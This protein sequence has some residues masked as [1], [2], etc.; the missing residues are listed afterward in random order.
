MA[1]DI[2]KMARTRRTVVGGIF[3]ELYR[4]PY[5]VT[6]QYKFARYTH[7]HVCGA[8]LIAPD[9]VLSA[10]HCYESSWGTPQVVIGDY[11]LSDN[12]YST[13]VFDVELLAI[14]PDWSFDY[15]GNPWFL[16]D[17]ILFKI[18]NGEQ[19]TKQPIRLNSNPNIPSPSHNKDK[20]VVMGWGA[21]EYSAKSTRLKE[22]TLE[23]QPDYM[24]FSSFPDQNIDPSILLCAQDL[25]GVVN[26]D[27][28][29]GDSGGPIIIKGGSS[30]QDLQ[31]G[32]VS[33]GPMPCA[34]DKPGYYTEISYFYDWIKQLTCNS[35]ASPPSHF[36]CPPTPSIT[37]GLRQ[38]PSMQPSSLME[39]T[40]SK[41]PITIA[42][43]ADKYPGDISWSIH[44]SKVQGGGLIYRSDPG[45]YDSREY[46]LDFIYETIYL[47]K[48]DSYVFTI[49]D[50]RGDGICCSE[51]FGYYFLYYGTKEEKGNF[52]E[53]K[54]IFWNIGDFQSST[55]RFFTTG[56][57]TLQAQSVTS[58]SFSE[59]DPY[60][61]IQLMLD[62]F[63]FH[64]SWDI[65]SAD[66]NNRMTVFAQKSKASY[67]VSS[68][69]LIT[70]IVH[71]PASKPFTFIIK[72]EHN[73]CLG[74]IGYVKVFEGSVYDQK[75][76]FERRNTF[77]SD[78]F[79][80]ILKGKT[81]SPSMAPSQQPSGVPS[82]Q[83]LSPQVVN[84]TSVPRISSS[85]MHNNPY[86]PLTSAPIFSIFIILIFLLF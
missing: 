27:S 46:Y 65:T 9:I 3:S 59:D 33:S 40:E 26:E 84:I 2:D 44:K 39:P 55:Q 60:I 25:D 17:L 85:D 49:S 73:N 76:L 70:E 1:S 81:L 48:N 54:R 68:K 74:D 19:S 61:T 50:A 22:T 15:K 29:R 30:S 16:N 69:Q 10:A 57:P 53:D 78:S 4:Y 83:K 20:L 13:E 63:P 72:S 86:V 66:D 58:V 31:V 36:Q 24:C 47:N 12:S 45:T 23:H 51:G 52:R 18:L 28:C 82:I 56:D 5:M 8:S 34:Q 64:V 41:V 7:T 75:L 42:I 32:L 67:V 77:T 35:S 37:H 11:D 38:T 71:L 43:R 79:N 80:F 6:L 62:Q 14:H 21:T